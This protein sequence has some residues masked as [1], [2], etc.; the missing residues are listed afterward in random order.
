VDKLGGV[1]RIDSLPGEGTRLLVTVPVRADGAP[2]SL[3]LQSVT[4]PKS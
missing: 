1:L 2:T 3:P 4:W